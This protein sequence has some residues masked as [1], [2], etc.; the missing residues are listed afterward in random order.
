MVRNSIGSWIVRGINVVMAGNRERAQEI[1]R[2]LLYRV[3]NHE[4]R[5]LRSVA[6]TIQESRR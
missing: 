6:A 5:K 4:Y 1:A 3:A 2:E